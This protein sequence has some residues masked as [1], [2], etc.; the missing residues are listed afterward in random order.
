M[1]DGFLLSKND[2]WRI[3]GLIFFKDKTYVKIKKHLMKNV[4]ESS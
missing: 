3:F 2:M 4:S 1:E